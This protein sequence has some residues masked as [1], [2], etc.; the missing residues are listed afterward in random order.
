MATRTPGR[1]TAGAQVA[2]NPREL[3]SKGLE[4]IL[5]NFV[6]PPMK[7]APLRNGSMNAPEVYQDATATGV[8][9]LAQAMGKDERMI[10]TNSFLPPVGDG[11]ARVYEI[12]FLDQSIHTIFIEKFKILSIPKPGY[13]QPDRL[14]SG[15]Y[16]YGSD[17][18][19]FTAQTAVMGIAGTYRSLRTGTS[20]DAITMTVVSKHMDN[21]I[22][23]VR[24]HTIIDLSLQLGTQFNDIHRVRADPR[25][26][27]G[28]AV[29][30]S[31]FLHLFVYSKKAFILQNTNSEK[32]AIS[33]VGGR[34]VASYVRDLSCSYIAEASSGD[35]DVCNL[36]PVELIPVGA[37][38]DFKYQIFNV[39]GLLGLTGENVA[40][41]VPPTIARYIA[42]TNGIKKTERILEHFGGTD[43][44]LDTMEDT[45]RV[46]TGAN[47]GPSTI[48][49]TYQPE[50]LEQAG[51][52]FSTYTEVTPL[53]RI[54]GESVEIKYTTPYAETASFL[55]TEAMS[56]TLYNI[57]G[58]SDLHGTT[59]PNKIK[60]NNEYSNRV[61]RKMT[62]D[63]KNNDITLC[64]AI[65]RVEVGN[66]IIFAGQAA[67]AHFCSP[68]MFFKSPQ[69]FDYSFGAFYR[70]VNV[71]PDPRRIVILPQACLSYMYPEE[72]EFYL[73]GLVSIC[74]CYHPTDASNDEMATKI[75]VLNR[76]NNQK[77]ITQ[78]GAIEL[79]KN[80]SMQLQNVRQQETNPSSWSREFNTILLNVT[81]PAEKDEDEDTF[82]AFLIKY[83]NMYPLNYN[84][85]ESKSGAYY[86]TLGIDIAGNFLA[87]DY[88]SGTTDRISL[89]EY[90]PPFVALSRT[91][92]SWRDESNNRR[93]IEIANT[94]PLDYFANLGGNAIHSAI[95]PG[96]AEDAIPN[97]TESNKKPFQV[98]DVA[99]DTYPREFSTDHQI[100]QQHLGHRNPPQGPDV[101][102]R[103]SAARFNT[104]A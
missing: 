33:Y 72:E 86:P 18:I 30:Q 90:N 63:V 67:V 15:G 98:W 70:F 85:K 19:T 1:T 42:K 60:W 6:N 13:N 77:I 21:F 48:M 44:A 24:P 59:S 92:Y 84:I 12:H 91:N 29:I 82:T 53:P 79:M 83:S 54:E 103:S 57:A 94:G 2:W 34:D 75:D 20:P 62:G 51:R 23:L 104:K 88:T 97:P 41:F 65:Q 4:N 81:P 56:Q 26:Q 45:M 16:E 52:L 14:F 95:K 66:T 61:E 10:F 22:H 32:P 35:P 38:P 36:N 73:R 46:I 80:P 78:P 37:L 68:L 76:F 31:L 27:K 8:M 3:A 69:T 9:S 99:A 39:T 93:T 96:S 87:D 7:L 64:I 25:E 28:V 49:A 89:E 11:F 100:F 71:I 17:R 50:L 102:Q 47:G 55:W 40:Q 43:L 5:G 101:H 74:Y 58:L